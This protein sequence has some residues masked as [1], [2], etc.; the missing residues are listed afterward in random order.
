MTKFGHRGI[1]NARFQRELCMKIT[2]IELY[3]LH[4]KVTSI[5]LKTSVPVLI[6]LT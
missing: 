2:S 3:E 5:E 6:T 1:E 4:M